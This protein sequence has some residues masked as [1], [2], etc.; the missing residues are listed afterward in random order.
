MA[1]LPEDASDA[2]H[3]AALS[4]LNDMLSFFIGN[5]MFLRQQDVATMALSLTSGRMPPMGSPAQLREFVT[6]SGDSIASSFQRC[7]AA[8]RRRYSRR[9][10]RAGSPLGFFRP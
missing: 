1:A 8:S 10:S 2:D 3:E 5:T 4:P 7:S 9:L 6:I